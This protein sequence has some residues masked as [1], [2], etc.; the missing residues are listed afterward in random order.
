[1]KTNVTQVERNGLCTS[2]GVCAG[3]CPKKCITFCY[4]K[5][6]NIPVVN[7]DKCIGCG[8]CYDVCPGKG[9][10]LNG[11]SKTLFGDIKNIHVDEF[12]GHYLNSYTGYSTNEE[13]RMHSATGGMVTQFL[14]WLL[15][16][17]E[18]DGAIVVRYSKNN[19]LEAE[20]FIATSQED[21]WN[22]R[23]SKYIVLSMDK[24]ARAIADGDYKRLIVVGLPCQI[25]GLRQLANKN[26]KIREAIIGYFSIYCSVNKTKLSILYY[27]KRYSVPLD[28]IASFSFR[29]DGCMGFM[30]FNDKEGNVLKK[31][32]YLSYWFGTHSFFSNPRC[33]LCIDQLGELAD[34]SFG[35]I[36]IKPY[37]DDLIGTN[38]IITRSE[39]WDV[40]LKRCNDEGFVSLNEID[41]DTLVS[42]QTYTRIFKKGAGVKTN[43]M[44]RNILGKKNP[45]YDYSYKGK[46]SFKNI[47]SELT[48]SMMRTIGRFPQ[49]WWIIRFLDNNKD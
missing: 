30:K 32:P 6:R 27:P 4:G 36:H 26:K 17:R 3:S 40:L 21:V 13:V 31:I 18:I 11:W 45:V 29:D 46:V 39:K 2:C 1:M 16:I 35:D 5:E 7:A 15:R 9:I 34:I 41:I 33:S 48:K 49:L 23:S 20:P 38:S 12:A 8:L 14:M 22:S 19:P 24:I 25:Q 47:A 10:E 42:S 28:R 37:S 44:I 43:M